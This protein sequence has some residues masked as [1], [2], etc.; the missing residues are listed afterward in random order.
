MSRIAV[1]EGQ[2]RE[3]AGH[4]GRVSRRRRPVTF[5]VTEEEYEK[6]CK[7]TIVH[8]ANSISDFARTALKHFRALDQRLNDEAKRANSLEA[9][10]GKLDSSLQEF[11]RIVENLG[12]IV[13]AVIGRADNYSG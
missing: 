9:S 12:R 3:P 1:L 2:A 7:D 6:L 10:V 5:R 11:S 4:G 8:G 13:G